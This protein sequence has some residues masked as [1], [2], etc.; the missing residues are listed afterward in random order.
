LGS[1]RLLNRLIRTEIER[2]AEKFGDDRRSPIVARESSQALETTALIANEP[3]TVILSEKGWIRAAKG[4]DIDVASLNYR[5]GDSF[6]EAVKTRSTQPVY[7][8]DSTGRA[9]S[10]S[11]HDLPSARTQGEPLTGRLNPPAGSSFTNLLVG[12]PDD[13]IV[14]ASDAGYGFRVQLKELL[15]KNKAGKTLLTLPNGAKVLKPAAVKSDEDLLAVVTLQGRLLIF[16]VSELP[17][18]AK[19]KGNKLIQIPSADLSNGSDKVVAIIAIAAAGELK[20]I[21]GKRHIQL[22]GADITHYSSSRAKRGL[23]LPRGFQRVDGLESE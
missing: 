22:K 8:L 9:Y 2:D 12:N 15:S 6:L 5:A 17:A 7:L 13:W 14:V 11:A 10:T 21:A 20:V 18:L 3:L 16:P 19:G 1:P 23:A 4:H